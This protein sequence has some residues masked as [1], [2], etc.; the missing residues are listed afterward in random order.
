MFSGLTAA[1]LVNYWVVA[2]LIGVDH[3]PA[4]SW[5]SDLAARGEPGGWRFA[6]LDALSGV[7]VVAFGLLLWHARERAIGGAD[8]GDAG[9]DP[10]P[11]D[12]S[13]RAGAGNPSHPRGEVD[14]TRVPESNMLVSGTPV[15]GA[16]RGGGALR[17]G[18]ILLIASGALAV[19]DALLPVSCARS[20]GE[21]CVRAGDLVDD[22]H[23]IESAL[24]VLATGGAMLLT[25]IG[26]RRG[27]GARWL[28]ALSLLGGVAF[29]LLSGLISMRESVEAFNDYKGWLQRGGQ[30]VLGAWLVAMAFVP[31]GRRPR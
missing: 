5:I 10:A 11:A 13:Q 22:L 6:L 20:L 18:L 26:L 12:S 21:G 14:P 3:D 15:S 7:A 8:S 29:L 9:L 16:S 28:A 30:L 17:W 24:A 23:E 1:A 25:G 2:L 4:F 31:R 27:G 19:A